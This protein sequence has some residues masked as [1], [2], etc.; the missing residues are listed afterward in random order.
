MFSRKIYA[1]WMS[2]IQ[3]EK[4]KGILEFIGPKGRVLDLGAGAGFLEE[5]I[6]WAIAL[7]VDLLNLKKTKAFKVLADGGNLPFKQEGFDLIFCIDTLHLLKGDKEIRRVLS[8]DGKAVVSLFCNEYNI[9]EKF[10]ALK[11][12]FR[13]WRILKEF[14]VGKKEMDAVLI[15]KK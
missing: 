3:K 5:Y 13:N 10:K 8:S 15:C 1:D 2:D 14:F 6:P 12:R 11:R 9:G 7:D 4:I